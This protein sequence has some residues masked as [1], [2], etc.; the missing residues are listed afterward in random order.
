MLR[1]EPEIH[2]GHFTGEERG[3]VF[4]RSERRFWCATTAIDWYV[5]RGAYSFGRCYRWWRDHNADE[6]REDH[7]KN[8][9]PSQ[10]T[11]AFQ[12]LIQSKI[13]V[14]PDRPCRSWV[15]WSRVRQRVSPS[16]LSARRYANSNQLFIGCC[17]ASV[18]QL[19][20]DCAAAPSQYWP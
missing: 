14:A 20:L 12:D 8:P 13:A 6:M 17:I 19:P 3:N 1:N 2:V 10:P 16:R 15:K 18:D 11:K 9:F 4:H 5:I 7:Q